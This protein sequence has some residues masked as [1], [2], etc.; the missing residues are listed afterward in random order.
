MQ[1]RVRSL[2]ELLAEFYDSGILLRGLGT[3]DPKWEAFQK[4]AADFIVETNVDEKHRKAS[5]ISKHVCG[6]LLDVAATGLPSYGS[7]ATLGEELMQFETSGGPLPIYHRDH[8]IHT[9]YVLL[10]GFYF[11]FSLEVI[12]GNRAKALTDC[13]YVLNTRLADS[14]PFDKELKT[15]SISDLSCWET[16]PTG[17]FYPRM[18]AQFIY[19]WSLASLGHDLG[20]PLSASSGALEERAQNL[21]KLIINLFQM[22]DDEAK[23]LLGDEVG[24]FLAFDILLGSQ[25]KPKS[26]LGRRYFGK[27]VDFRR[28]M[29]NRLTRIAGEERN[30]SNH[31]TRHAAYT[32]FSSESGEHGAVGAYQV[33][34]MYFL[35][36]FLKAGIATEETSQ[37]RDWLFFGTELDAVAACFI[38]NTFLDHVP[39]VNLEGSPIVYLLILCDELQQFGRPLRSA[40][41]P[42]LE[43]YGNSLNTV[44]IGFTSQGGL[45]FRFLANPWELPPEAEKRQSESLQRLEKLKPSPVASL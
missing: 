45:T 3:G 8:H 16:T 10:L 12:L 22:S 31:I 9:V 7:I 40:S 19:A 23:V 43:Q 26:E 32:G 44:E 14:Q 39:I 41:S 4:L 17:M 6:E 37:L 28:L 36:R 11:F 18:I 29:S 15:G 42:T 30:W 27:S 35:S 38:H 33:L 13:Y 5:G 25:L 2:N 1:T 34:F 21:V 24:L 20:Y